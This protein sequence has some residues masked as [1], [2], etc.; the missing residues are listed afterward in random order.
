MW[1]CLAFKYPFSFQI[2]AWTCSTKDAYLELVYMSSLFSFPNSK[3]H[4]RAFN[5]ASCAEVTGGKAW[6]SI[7]LC[8]EAMA[9]PA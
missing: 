5:S 1:L 2:A 3:A 7:I 9:Y 6:T 8:E 4:V